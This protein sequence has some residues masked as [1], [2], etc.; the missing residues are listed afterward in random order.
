MLDID[1]KYPLEINAD[2]FGKKK[3]LFYLLAKV[4]DKNELVVIAS[5][6][7]KNNLLRIKEASITSKHIK[8]QIENFIE[9][10]KE[11]FKESE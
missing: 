4:K 11:R 1:W 7:I 6:N 5:Y 3:E 2:I 8:H 9:I 10:C